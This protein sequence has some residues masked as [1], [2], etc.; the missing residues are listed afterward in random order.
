LHEKQILGKTNKQRQKSYGYFI[1]K[2]KSTSS[3]LFLKTV[4]DGEVNNKVR[5]QGST[6]MRVLNVME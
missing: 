5:Q 3:N 1:K 2:L 4:A 6:F